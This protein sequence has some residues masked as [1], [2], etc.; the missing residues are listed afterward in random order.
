MR[1]DVF[2]ETYKGFVFL[3]TRILKNGEI[4]IWNQYWYVD[5]HPGLQGYVIKD[6]AYA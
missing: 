5:Y 6:L 3:A 2:E 1:I 4:K